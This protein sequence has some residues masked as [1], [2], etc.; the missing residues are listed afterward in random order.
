MR[1]K[2]VDIYTLEIPF[3]HALVIPIGT[4]TGAQNVVIKINTHCGMVGWGESSPFAPITGD[5]Q[6]SITQARKNPREK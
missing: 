4:L 3:E 2:S 6:A 1:I 5:T